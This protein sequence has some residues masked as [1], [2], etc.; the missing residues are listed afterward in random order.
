MS[1]VIRRLDQLSTAIRV[2]NY[3]GLR[4]PICAVVQLAHQPPGV[5][6]QVVL[7][8]SKVKPVAGEVGGKTPFLIRLGEW[9][10]D[11]ARGWQWLENVTVLACLGRAELIDE[12][13][14]RVTPEEG[15]G[16]S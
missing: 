13:T 6:H 4:Y 1:S 8:P 2:R 9:P 16:V 10:G 12:K 7:D 15:K 3:G 14:V 11:E 5:V